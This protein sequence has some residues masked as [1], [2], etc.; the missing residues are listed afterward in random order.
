[1]E[2]DNTVRA[3]AS[4]TGSDIGTALSAIQRFTDRLEHE[5]IPTLP[6]GD[7][8][9][10][11][12]DLVK[13][14]QVSP[15]TVSRALQE[16]S[17]RGLVITRP[18][19]GSFVNRLDVT[20][21][22][23]DT[24]WQSVPLGARALVS[25][26]LQ[27]MFEGA[28]PG[29]LGLSVGYTDASLHPSQAIN[30]ATVRA[31]RKANVWDRQG[32]AGNEALRTWFAQNIGQAQAQDVLIAPGGQAAV[33]TVLRALT[34]PGD[35]VVFESPT[36]FG[37]LAVA[38][39][40]GMR[41]VPV[42]SDADGLR[43]D[44]LEATLKAS[45]AKVIYLQPLYA[46]PNGSTLK[47][48]R[49]EELVALARRLDVF[50]IEDDYGR[51]F[52]LE[53]HAPPALWTLAPERTVYI[54]SLTKATT[55]GLRIAGVI[56]LGPVMRRLQLKRTVDDFFVAGLLQEIALEFLTDSTWP[57]HLRRLREQIRSRR[58]FALQALERHFP[59]ARV[60]CVPKGGFS[61]WLELPAGCHDIQFAFQAALAGVHINPGQPSFPAE[62]P[63]TFFRISLAGANESVLLE[64]IKR[65]G[66]V[67]R[68]GLET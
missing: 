36:Y 27:R 31:M 45:K 51:D 8:L 16:L 33:S 22:P 39:S 20:L 55:P 46:N 26:D 43:V 53:G 21:E 28:R 35:P 41:I 59:E 24:A 30:R 25:D 56:A 52:Q 2:Y 47:P 1:M 9:P 57:K 37:A 65:L 58:D 66:Q 60:T 18:G 12:R 29:L 61:L 7:R 19:D 48:E 23:I 17:R 32:V 34:E 42:P 64:G 3:A 68:T 67:W 13:R 44:M 5:V 54:R 6:A 40:A 10:S 62:A 63:G 15:V 38:Q 4:N 11:V 49:R 14:Y 50:L